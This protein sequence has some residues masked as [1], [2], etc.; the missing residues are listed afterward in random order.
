MYKH[1][2]LCSR[3]FTNFYSLCLRHGHG[4]KEEKWIKVELV[5]I[6]QQQQLRRGGGKEESIWR[7]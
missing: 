3:K 7:G 5:E 1:E 4:A 6:S 2:I